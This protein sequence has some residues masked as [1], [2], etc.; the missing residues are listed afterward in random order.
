MN[1]LDRFLEKFG[2]EKKK[3]V[4]ASALIVVM[5]F[6][7]GRLFAGKGPK[8]TI[9]AAVAA[10][11]IPNQKQG[12]TETE[13]PLVELP[14]IKGRND[15]LARDFFAVGTDGLNDD[16]VDIITINSNEEIAKKITNKMELEVIEAG[17]YP[18]AF[19]NNKLLAVGDKLII[20]DK[21]EKYECKITAIKNNR[22]F[23]K[24][25]EIEIVLKLAHA[26]EP[27]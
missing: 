12:N 23:I 25:G 16:N 24:C 26:I 9:A 21:L 8:K 11:T 20:T 15:V 2:I 5:I 3:A 10:K 22:V 13:M 6:M 17:R 27:D 19:I 14:K 1:S 4:V 7:W 18:R